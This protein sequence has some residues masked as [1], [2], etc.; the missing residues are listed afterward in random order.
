AKA[1]VEAYPNATWRGGVEVYE[2]EDPEK[3]T[4]FEQ[5]WKEIE[6]RL[7]VWSV[8]QAVDILAGLST[9]AVLLIGAAGEPDLTKE[10][11]RNGELLFLKPYSGGGGPGGR[12]RA[13][14]QA[15][16]F[17]ASVSIQHFELDP[18]SPRFGEPS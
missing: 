11:P 4:A 3:D 12:S 6:Q 14:A 5:A 18:Q 9:Y 1:V 17:D 2:D 13:Q 7:G 16:A 15:Q 10:L 8:L